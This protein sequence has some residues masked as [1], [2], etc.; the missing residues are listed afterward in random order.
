MCKL[1]FYDRILSIRRTFL[2][3]R[4]LWIHQTKNLNMEKMKVCLVIVA[5]MVL[6]MVVFAPVMLVFSCGMNGE[7][8]VWN[9]VGAAY[10]VALSFG[11]KKLGR[12]I[13]F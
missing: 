10:L 4:R 9:F 1:I 8:T 12:W 3:Q 6:A 2:L 13:G 7:V 11:L 5:L